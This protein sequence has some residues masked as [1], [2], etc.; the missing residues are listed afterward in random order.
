MHHQH[1]DQ[2]CF[3]G[4][5]KTRVCRYKSKPSHGPYCSPTEWTEWIT[6]WGGRDLVL[7]QFVNPDVCEA[8]NR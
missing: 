8:R 6:V 2:C 4:S 3:C 5:T 7:G 1:T